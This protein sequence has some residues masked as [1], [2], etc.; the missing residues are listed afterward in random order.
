MVE[1]LIL[2]RSVSKN[3]DKVSVLFT[4]FINRNQ[5]QNLSCD[6][7]FHFHENE[8]SFDKRGFG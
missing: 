7:K 4:I 3:D 6:N 2:W 1:S 5:R 8:K